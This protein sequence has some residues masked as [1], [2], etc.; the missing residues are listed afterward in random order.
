NPETNRHLGAGVFSLRAEVL[1]D[2][3][4]E[5]IAL[6]VAAMAIVLIACANLASLLLARSA[7]RRGEYAVRLSLGATR[8]QLAR[9]V[10]VE[11]L[12]LSIAGGAIGL[13]IPLVM[14]ALLERLVP[15]GLQAPIVSIVDWRLL[16]FA[17]AL[18]IGTGLA[19]SIGP[20]LQS[21]RASTAQA[22]QQHA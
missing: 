4:I 12:C 9:Q 17:G 7:G 21:A 6:M 16:S 8:T 1:G 19:F 11:A 10:V 5:L 2:T 13:A 15:A 3:R 18:S 14:G 20:A 22:L